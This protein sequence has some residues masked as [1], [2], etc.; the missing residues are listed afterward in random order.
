MLTELE[1][2]GFTVMVMLLLVAVDEVTQLMDEV[3]IQL[4]TSLLFNEEVVYVLLFDPTGEPFLY[5]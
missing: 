5:H 4:I 3:I 2:Y 1:M